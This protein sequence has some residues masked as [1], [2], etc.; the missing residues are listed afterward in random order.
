MLSSP[1]VTRVL[2]VPSGT[3]LPA[4]P[5]RLA[6]NDWILPQHMS[7]GL[8]H[9]YAKPAA[10]KESEF[11]SPDALA[12]SLEQL[13]AH[14]PLLA[15]RFV[16]NAA[17]GTLEIDTLDAGCTFLTARTEA[18]IEDLPLDE[19]RFT[20]TRAL[21]Y[22]LQLMPPFDYAAPTSGPIL[23]VQH[24]RF[25]CGG[26]SL[27]VQLHHYVGDMQSFVQMMGDWTHLHRA[28]QAGEAS[29]ALPQPPTL[30]RSLFNRISAED[31]AR[32]L[33]GHTELTHKLKDAA[34]AADASSTATA[35][36]PAAGSTP[37]SRCFRFQPDELARLKQAA[38]SSSGQWVSTF[39]ALAAHLCR[40]TFRARHPEMLGGDAASKEPFASKIYV[41][42][43][44]RSRLRDPP[45]PPRYFGNAALYT[46]LHFPDSAAALLAPASSLSDTAAAVHNAVAANSGVAQWRTMAWISAQA[47]K[48]QIEPAFDLD[49]RDF[50]VTSWLKFGMHDAAQFEHGQRPLRICLPP[51]PGMHGIAILFPT[52]EEGPL[53][54]GAARAGGLAPS[55]APEAPVDVLLGLSEEQMERLERD[56]EFRKF[57]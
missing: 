57:R 29:P 32:H 2:H 50:A 9:F 19:G 37:I 49:R 45:C 53:A 47:D 24:T 15:G 21:P 35:A 38:S 6:P 13:L 46:S 1:P 25:A 54:E 52:P 51:F 23:S 14:Y 44:W 28:L 43:N 26:V 11:M 40:A 55:P 30:D 10:A 42:T 27:G 48:E 18:R 12:T 56:A 34:P 4:T 39:E 33:Q 17:E 8:L 3:A 20:G 7:I 36:A 5:I 41:A 16:R 31:I 22:S